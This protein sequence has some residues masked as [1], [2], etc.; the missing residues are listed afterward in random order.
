MY[1]VDGDAQK[2]T[3]IAPLNGPTVCIITAVNTTE[4]KI[5]QTVDGTRTDVDEIK[6]GQVYLIGAG[7]EV[8]FAPGVEVWA[9]FWDDQEQGQS[10]T[11]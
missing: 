3:T 11:A 2:S 10:G 1:H 6:R 9:S 8:E 4:G 7:T 5:T